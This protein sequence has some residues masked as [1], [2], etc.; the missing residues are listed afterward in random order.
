[1]SSKQLFSSW[2]ALNSISYEDYLQLLDFNA[3][4]HQDFSEAA[5]AV[6]FIERLHSF[7]DKLIVIDTD[8]DCDGVMAGLVLEGSLKRLGF[9]TATYHPS[10]HDG[11]GLT[12]A[13]AEHI[14]E[15]YPEAEVVITADNGINCR[16]GIKY[17]TDKGIKVLV[18]DHH[19]GEV[20]L[21]PDTAEVCV[22]VNRGDKPDMYKFKGISGAQTAWK[23]MDLY[24]SKYGSSIDVSYIKALKLFASIS[25]M[26]DVMP[27]LSENRKDVRDL[28]DTVNSQKFA[29]MAAANDYIKR[30]KTF[31]EKFGDKRVTIDSFGFA[32][33]PAINSSRRMLGESELAFKAFDSNPAVAEMSINGL[34]RMNDLRKTAK[35]DALKTIDKRV[36]SPYIAVGVTDAKSGILGLIASDL[37]NSEGRSALAFKH[38]GDY[39][40]SSGR[41]WRHNSIY[42]ILTEVKNRESEIDLQ[43]GG[44]SHALGCSVAAKDFD[45]FCKTIETVAEEM[46]KDVE[47]EVPKML[48]VDFRELLMSK[49]LLAELQDVSSKLDMIEPL[50]HGMVGLK[51][52]TTTSNAEM[53]RYGFEYFGRSYEHLKYVSPD[54][55]LEILLF[56]KA[57]QVKFA[58]DEIVLEMS[59]KFNYGKCTIVIDG[60]RER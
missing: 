57:D 56:F 25:I 55:K 38:V 50:P 12:L 33:I 1:M 35:K 22:N 3:Y 9:K 19:K 60:V 48:E 11:Y 5:D 34:M 17:L 51:L 31:I 54:K 13:E 30:L 6:E 15:K 16:E 58:S 20:D 8:Y 43:F 24:A 26:S 39:Y 53:M 40:R 49:S 47:P 7:K 42:D 14:F 2:L 52:Q 44:H 32:I 29:A 27:I 46:Y 59:V 45:L 10:E 41:G 21:F 18:T 23:L 37:A 36:D 28:I 4:E